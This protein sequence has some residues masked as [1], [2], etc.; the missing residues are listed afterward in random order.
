MI[1]FLF[2]DLMGDEEHAYVY[3]CSECA[4]KYKLPTSDSCCDGNVCL[5]KCCGNKTSLVHYV[6][7]YRT[8]AEMDP[9]TKQAMIDRQSAILACAETDVK[10]LWR[11]TIGHGEPMTHEQENL[12]DEVYQKIVQL[13]NWVIK[14]ETPA[15]G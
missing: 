1:P 9:S 2:D 8:K 13:S 7:D 12:L 5:V 10:Q 6:W 4:T 11:A 3:V 14:N 15:K